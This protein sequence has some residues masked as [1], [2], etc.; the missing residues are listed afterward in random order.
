MPLLTVF[1]PITIDLFIRLMNLQ[2]PGIAAITIYRFNYMLP[3]PFV[4]AIAM[5]SAVESLRPWFRRQDAEFTGKRSNTDLIKAC[6]IVI[7][8][9]GLIFPIQNRWIDAPFSRLYTLTGHCR[10]DAGRWKDLTDFVGNLQKPI[11]ITDPNT[12]LIFSYL[13]PEHP[14]RGLQWMDSKEPDTKFCEITKQRPELLTNGIVVIN[15]R[16]GVPS[17]TGRISWHWSGNAFL[18]SRYYSPEA[19]KFVESHTNRFKLLWA[20][21]RIEVFQI[22][23]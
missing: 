6:V 9:V 4:A 5:G 2:V 1:N 18:T 21:D 7:G 11:L 16:D 12:C 23:P 3:L 22:R 17:E 19:I 15:R 8:L 14:A 20:K 13:Y 10:N